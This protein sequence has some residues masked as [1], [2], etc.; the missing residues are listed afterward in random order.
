MNALSATV[1]FVDGIARLVREIMTCGERIR[2]FGSKV[3]RQDPGGEDVG[4]EDD[5]RPTMRQPRDD[6]ADGGVGEKCVQTHGK[7]LLIAFVYSRG[8]HLLWDRTS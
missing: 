6:I 8:I 7:H 4:S 2:A 1:I 5:E 3:A